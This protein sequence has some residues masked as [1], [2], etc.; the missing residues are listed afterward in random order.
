MFIRRAARF[1]NISLRNDPKRLVGMIRRRGLESLAR[2]QRGITL[3][4]FGDINYEVDMTIHRVMKKYYYRTHEMFLERVFDK[5]LTPDLSFFDV[6]ANCGYWSIYALSRVGRMGEVHA[7]EPVPRYFTFVQRLAVLNPNYK[8]YT[9]NVACGAR[10]GRFLMTVVLPR[11][12]NF[13]NFDT[14]I[15]SSSL[16]P[17]F[18]DHAK[19]LTTTIDVNVIKFDDYVWEHSIDLERIG[20]IK[21]DVEGFESEVLSG[22]HNVLSKSGRKVPLLC[23]ISTDLKRTEPIDGGRVIVNLEQYGYKCLNANDLQPIDRKALNF[24]ENILCV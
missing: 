19:E 15:G 23:E 21:I 11:N 22:M 9:N 10:P 24:Q 20:L 8:V 6:G 5:Y 18:L 7:F 3:T 12:D 16:F 14:S 2:S 1:V 17:G 4:R 13:D